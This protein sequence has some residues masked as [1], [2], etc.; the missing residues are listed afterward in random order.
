LFRKDN[1]PLNQKRLKK[2]PGSKRV[3]DGALADSSATRTFLHWNTLPLGASARINDLHGLAAREMSGPEIHEVVELF[4][5]AAERAA[6]AE[7]DGIE[8]HSANGYLFTQFLSSAI[9]DRTDRYGG[10]LKN[11]T[12]LLLEV[13]QA[14]Q[15]SVGRQFPLIVKLTGRHLHRAFGVLPTGD[16]NTL[17]DAIQLH[18]GASKQACTHCMFPW[19]TPFLILTIPLASFPWTSF[20]GRMHR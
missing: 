4:A 2:L 17:E 10:V 16:G 8:L 5:R 15:D 18:N 13:I 6:S 19:E 1:G 20:C 14:I 12:R 9:N 3:A 11:R 7:M